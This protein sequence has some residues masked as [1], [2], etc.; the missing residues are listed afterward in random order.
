MVG[1]QS[2]PPPDTYKPGK[3]AKAAAAN[4]NPGAV[5]RVMG[6][7]AT[8]RLQAATN[9]KTRNISVLKAISISRHG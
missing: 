6:L 4:V 1:E 2:V 5:A 7:P 3:Q 9:Q 8:C